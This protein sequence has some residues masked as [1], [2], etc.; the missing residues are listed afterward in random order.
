MKKIII[1]LFLLLLPLVTASYNRDIKLQAKVLEKE[2]LIEYETFVTDITPTHWVVYKID[3]WV[4]SYVK[5]KP[6]FRPR[7]VYKT[8]KYAEGDCSDRSY[9]K[10]VMLRYLGYKVRLVYGFSDIWFPHDWY[11]YYDEGKWSS[12]EYGLK[13]VG[14]GQW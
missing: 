2:A 9:L 13:K 14:R 6:Y 1:I 5:Y 8:W 4:D 7:G 3:V 11:E 12:I 10:F